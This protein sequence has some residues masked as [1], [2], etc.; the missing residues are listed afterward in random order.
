MLAEDEAA[1]PKC[2][3]PWLIY[4]RGWMQNCSAAPAAWRHALGEADGDKELR[5]LGVNAQ[6]D[7]FSSSPELSH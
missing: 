6:E 3:N 4:H 2:L 5:G 1:V 7:T